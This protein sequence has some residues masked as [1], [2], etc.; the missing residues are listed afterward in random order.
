MTFQLST[1]DFN[2]FLFAVM[3][4]VEFVVEVHF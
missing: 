3:P 1:L 4:S 2:S